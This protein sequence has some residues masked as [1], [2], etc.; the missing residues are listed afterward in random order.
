MQ[1]YNQQLALK[2]LLKIVIYID[3]NRII[4]KISSFHII[5]KEFKAIKL[6]LRIYAYN[7]VYM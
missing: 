4:E 5:P 1:L 7:T 3:K 2:P 6:F